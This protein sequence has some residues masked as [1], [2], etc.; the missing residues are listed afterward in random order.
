MENTNN[1][2]AIV[3]SETQVP[4]DMQKSLIEYF[5]P[6]L[7]QAADWK[8]KAESL[9]VTD[10]TQTH[11]MKMAREARLAIR[12]IRLAADKTRKMLKE[13][14]L[15]YG[16]AVQGAYN[17]IEA[18]ISPIESHLEKQ[19]KFKELYELRQKEK[20]RLEREELSKDV[21]EYM[22]VNINLGE[23]T[24][25]DFERMLNG[26]ILQKQA[27]EQ[28]AIKAEEER[29]ARMEAEAEER[30]RLRVELDR[31]EMEQRKANIEAAKLKKE[32]EAKL[33]SERAERERLEAELKAKQE[34][35]LKAEQ[36]R[37]AAIEAELSKGDKAKL[38]DLI[39]DLEALQSKYEFKAKKNKALYKIVVELLG[40]II[41]YINSK[42]I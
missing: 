28:A 19:E 34:A 27:A 25:T 8:E 38:S 21:R 42:N 24:Q 41:V 10:I 18:V 16:R 36:E 31:L 7:K 23:I 9:V 3:I 12:E 17:V 1:E 13:E 6:F 15:K 33:A 29:Q 30:D 4:E 11:E 26:A 32:A 40:K 35:E 39:S 22:I 37:Q 20:L 2:L 5:T 14:S